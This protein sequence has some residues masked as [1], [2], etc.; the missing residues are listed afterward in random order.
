M[1]PKPTK[2]SKVL[3]KGSYQHTLDQ[4]GRIIIPAKLKKFISEEADDTLVMLPG[5]HKCIEVYPK[6]NWNRKESQYASLDIEDEAVLFLIRSQMNRAHEDKMD[7]Q[8]RILVPAS[9]LKHANIQTDVLIVGTLD[10]IEFWNPVEYDEYFKS[11]TESLAA[12]K[13]RLLVKK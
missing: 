9:L 13:A 7:P 2:W 11:Q 1:V 5:T 10:R 4:K 8:S 3:F 6:D 12:L